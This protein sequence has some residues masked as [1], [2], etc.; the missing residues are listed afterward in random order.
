M[1]DS[2][3]NYIYPAQRTFVMNENIIRRKF[4]LSLSPPPPHQLFFARIREKVLLSRKLYNNIVR[5]E[6]SLYT[7]IYNN[8]ICPKGSRWQ[9][10]PLRVG[11]RQRGL[12]IRRLRMRRL[13]GQHLH[14]RHWISKSNWP[15]PMVRRALPRH[16]GN[17]LQQRRL[18]RSDDCI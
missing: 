9:G 2:R 13:R 4:S 18:Q 17:H 15:I 7:Y 10:Q 5:V 12:E 11:L 1:L 8:C 6:Y 14:N 3:P 16:F